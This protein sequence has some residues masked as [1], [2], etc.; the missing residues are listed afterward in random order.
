MAGRTD[1]DDVLR[2][3]DMRRTAFLADDVMSAG[4]FGVP[5]NLAGKSTK[6]GHKAFNYLLAIPALCLGF[7]LALKPCSFDLGL[8]WLESGAFHLCLLLRVVNRHKITGVNRDMNRFIIAN[9]RRISLPYQAH[10]KL[11]KI[12]GF[13]DLD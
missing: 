2:R 3:Y 12:G 8:A 7:R 6:T 11:V 4:C 1:H 5:A 13:K 9:I 10:N